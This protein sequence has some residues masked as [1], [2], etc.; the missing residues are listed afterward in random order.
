MIT[1]H[2]LKWEVEHHPT[3]KPCNSGEDADFFGKERHFLPIR[4]QFNQTKIYLAVHVVRAV[5]FNVDFLFSV[6]L[7]TLFD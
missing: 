3:I 4:E 2:C 6:L 7:S 1:S 5:C